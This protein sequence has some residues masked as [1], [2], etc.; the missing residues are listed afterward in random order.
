M[1]A[2]WMKKGSD[3]KHLEEKEKVEAEVRKQQQGKMFRFSLGDG[4]EGELT[5][6][7]GEVTKEGFLNPPRYYEHS[8]FLNGK[9][10]NYVC[11]EK[12]SP[13]SGVVCPI[14]EGDPQDRPSL[15]ALFTVI[16]HRTFKGKSGKEYKDTRK[17]LV[18]KPKSYEDLTKWAG[19]LGGLAGQRFAVSRNGEKSPSIGSLYIPLAKSP[20]AD[21][22]K[23]YTHEVTDPKTNQKSIVTSFEPADYEAE[24]I[25]RDEAELRALGFGKSVQ[26]GKPASADYKNQL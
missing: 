19:A 20:V 12:T 26:Q 1:A 6:V 21:L 22:K 16:D 23:Q 4:E 2:A 3:A 24:V 15:V 18:A 17:I 14:C 10:N 13:E 11:P 7:D 8:H 5:F 9:V 25:Y